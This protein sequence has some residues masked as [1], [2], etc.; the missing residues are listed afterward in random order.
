MPNK[1]KGSSKYAQDPTFLVEKIR[2]RNGGCRKRYFTLL[3]HKVI[4]GVVVSIPSSHPR[5]LGFDSL[6][7]NLAGNSNGRNLTCP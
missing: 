7:E 1:T 4:C 3:K 6:M 2:S 5:R